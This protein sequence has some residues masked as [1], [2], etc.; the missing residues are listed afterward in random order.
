MRSSKTRFTSNH[1]TIM[2]AIGNCSKGQAVQNVV[3]TPPPNADLLSGINMYMYVLEQLYG[4]NTNIL[5]F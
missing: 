3:S 2:Y 5:E 1:A 4:F